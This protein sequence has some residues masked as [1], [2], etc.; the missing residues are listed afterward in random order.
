VVQIA[1]ADVM[2][3]LQEKKAVESLEKLINEEDVNSSAKQRMEESI[4]RII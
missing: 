2:V 1:L 3:L 4:Q